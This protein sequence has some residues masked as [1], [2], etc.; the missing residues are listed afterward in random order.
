MRYLHST[1]DGMVG[2]GGECRGSQLSGRTVV[3]HCCIPRELEYVS[4][5]RGDGE[6]RL[7]AAET[8]HPA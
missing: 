4:D 7:T 5:G 2:L 1:V 3:P 6:E 8:G